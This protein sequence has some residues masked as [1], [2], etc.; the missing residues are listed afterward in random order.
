MSR[1]RHATTN[2]ASRVRA[3]ALCGLAALLIAGCSKPSDPATPGA[4]V[5]TDVNNVFAMLMQ[6][7]NIDEAAQQYQQMDNEL[8]Q[9]LSQAIPVLA[10]WHVGSEG[11]QTSCASDYPGIDFDG[12]T[13]AFPSNVVNGNLPDTDYEKALGIIGL[14]AQK[15][16]FTPQPQ[17]LHDTPGSHDAVFHNVHDDGE[18]SFG[19]AANTSLRVSL[20]CHLTAE[21]K[22]RGHPSPSPTY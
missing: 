9:A 10:S 13:R 4:T 19:T 14:T 15:Y 16:G 7:P 22:Q 6:R 21:A 5:N 3:V 8:R 12:Q 1:Q 2:P 18:I 17:R 11:G 20:G